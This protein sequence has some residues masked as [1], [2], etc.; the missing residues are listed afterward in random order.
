MDIISQAHALINSTGYAAIH[1][2][3]FVECL[4]NLSLLLQDDEM[5]KLYGGLFD[6]LLDAHAAHNA[7]LARQKMF[8]VLFDGAPLSC[9]PS[10]N[11]TPVKDENVTPRSS[12]VDKLA[13]AAVLTPRASPLRVRQ[14]KF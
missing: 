8:S 11:T 1:P 10:L 2:N 7:E 14:L 3:E 12:P 9:C 6:A 5:Y 4:G 13:V